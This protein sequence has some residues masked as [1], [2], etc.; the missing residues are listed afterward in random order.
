MS[1]DRIARNKQFL[2][3][4]ATPPTL[5]QHQTLIRSA[6]EDQVT[7]ICE[8]ILNALAGNIQLT[9]SEV[10]TIGGYKK[11]LRRVCNRKRMSWTSRRKILLKMGKVISFLVG[12]SLN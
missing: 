10:K 2:Q 5:K 6:T 7:A 1:S 11:D 3:F 12:K 8:I 9:P 4:I